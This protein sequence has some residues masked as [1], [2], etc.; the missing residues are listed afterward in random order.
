M[1]FGCCLNLLAKGDDV[2]GIE[3]V[4]L[5]AKTGYDYIE[6]PL[7]QVSMLSDNEFNMLL[8][9][10]DHAGIPCL[11]CSNF[12]PAHIRTTGTQVNLQQIHEYLTHSLSR[13]RKL[14]V[15][16]VVYGS[17]ASRN[18]ENS[19]PRELA[20]IQLVRALQIM[21]DYAAPDL[22]IAIEHV[23][24]LEGN[25]VYTVEESCMLQEICRSEQ[26][27]I[28]AD[29][30]H[31]AVEREPLDNLALAEGRLIHVHT[32]NPVGR[33]FPKPSDGTDYVKLFQVLHAINYNGSI[34]VEAFSD[35]PERDAPIALETL[36]QAYKQAFR[37]ANA[38]HAPVSGE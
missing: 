14:G 22:Q 30:Y 8:K 29:T 1:L 10:I 19:Y 3:F 33:I 17:P 25:L 38:T 34:S 12:F 6:M 23:C 36:Q 7:T 24:H 28:L 27:G 32:A 11:R 26:V 20:M 16:V 15:K 5:M 13:A 37:T 2:L 31:M 9:R 18:V 35:N 21:G 4:E